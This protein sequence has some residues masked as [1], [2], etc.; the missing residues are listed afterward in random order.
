MITNL[1][2]VGCAGGFDPFL[3]QEIPAGETGACSFRT[4]CQTFNATRRSITSHSTLQ[5]SIRG[6]RQ[7]HGVAIAS[8]EPSPDTD[9]A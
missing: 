8:H 6:L 5:H 4:T 9:V 7:I 1:L 3:L 2:F